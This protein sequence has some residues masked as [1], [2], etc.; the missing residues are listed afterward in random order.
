MQPCHWET[1]HGGC[2]VVGKPHPSHSFTKPHP[3]VYKTT[4]AALEKIPNGWNLVD[5]KSMFTRWRGRLSIPSY[6]SMCV[7]TLRTFEIPHKC[8]HITG[9]ISF[10]VEVDGSYL[11]ERRGRS[12]NPP[13]PPISSASPFNERLSLKFF[14]HDS[15]VDGGGEFIQ[16]EVFQTLPKRKRTQKLGQ[17]KNL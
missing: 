5:E 11:L 13:P 3:T 10:G 16:C 14:I 4:W 6:E 9:Q 7:G 2:V 12:L 17:H 15:W 1:V 8:S